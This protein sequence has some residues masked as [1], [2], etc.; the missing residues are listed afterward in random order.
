M[1][2]CRLGCRRRR[3]A[4]TGCSGHSGE[5]VV[6][7]EHEAAGL[8]GSVMTPSIAV[9]T[10]LAKVFW[11][12]DVDGREV[13]PIAS[14]RTEGAA[15]A[16]LKL[17]PVRPIWPTARLSRGM[18]QS[19]PGAGFFVAV[20]RHWSAQMSTNP[21]FCRLECQG[22]GGSVTSAIRDARKASCKPSSDFVPTRS[23][24]LWQAAGPSQGCGNRV[25]S[26]F[27]ASIRWLA[28]RV[29]RCRPSKS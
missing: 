18:S 20:P 29:P 28:P 6:V 25:A 24:R 1:S 8:I 10:Y 22:P 7:G 21:D 27:P 11:P 16:A 9:M 17:V 3:S 5:G 2:R 14:V 19:V 12:R 23:R 13:Q 26:R 15:A 4:L